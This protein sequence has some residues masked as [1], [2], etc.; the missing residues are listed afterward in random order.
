MAYNRMFSRENGIL[1]LFSLR[2][3]LT[4]IT[5]VGWQGG[6]GVFGKDVAVQRLYVCRRFYSA[7]YFFLLRLMQIFG[8][9]CH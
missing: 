7:D 5:H 9:D 8:R 2:N 1:H 6:A 4:Y 3:L